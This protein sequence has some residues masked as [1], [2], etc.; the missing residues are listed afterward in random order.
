[1]YVLFVMFLATAFVGIAFTVEIHLRFGKATDNPK[2]QA[3]AMTVLCIMGLSEIFMVLAGV[4]ALVVRRR[5]RAAIKERWLKSIATQPETEQEAIEYQ[6][7]LRKKAT[8]EP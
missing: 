3:G 4:L 7:R 8:T 5:Q 6:D 1:M 2:A